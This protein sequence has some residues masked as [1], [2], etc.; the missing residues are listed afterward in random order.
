MRVGWWE[1]GGV[2]EDGWG[3]GSEVGERR[4]EVSI[5]CG[6]PNYTLTNEGNLVECKEILKLS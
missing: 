6:K 5:Q 1:A 3:M 2:G 4:S